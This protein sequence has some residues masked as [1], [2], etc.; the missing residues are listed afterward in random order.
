MPGL[1]RLTQEPDG[2]HRL[3]RHESFSVRRYNMP[4]DMLSPG[5]SRR[6]MLSG[7][8]GWRRRE[9][10][11]RFVAAGCFYSS[12]STTFGSIR[13]ARHAGSQL[14][15]TATAVIVAIT[16]AIVTIS[17]GCTPNSRDAISRFTASAPARPMVTP[18][19]VT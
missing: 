8:G 5:V 13:D 2:S 17:V 14:A 7:T 16:K 19:I 11:G 6:S 18:N 10:G 3:D 9:N 15:I 12:L 4:K 1:R